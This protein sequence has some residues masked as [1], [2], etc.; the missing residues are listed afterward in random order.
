MYVITLTLF[1]VE[2]NLDKMGA[3]LNTKRVSD[4]LKSEWSNVEDGEKPVQ[5]MGGGEWVGSDEDCERLIRQLKLTE[6]IEEPE[7][8]THTITEKDIQQGH[9]YLTHHVD[10]GVKIEGD[11]NS[12]KQYVDTISET[13]RESGGELPNYIT[14]MFFGVE[15]D[16][17]RFYNLD[18]DNWDTVKAGDVVLTREEEE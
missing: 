4:D 11:I 14:D 6:L 9:R 10:G 12:L 15:V 7:P 3:V 5:L 8:K 18:E 16:Y 2:G 13:V 1:R 17:Q